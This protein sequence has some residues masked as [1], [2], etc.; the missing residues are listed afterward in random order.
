[1][2]KPLRVV[3]LGGGMIG[4]IHR[5]SAL[6]SGA[7]IVGTMASSPE[8]SNLLAASWDTHALRTL[9]EL[10]SFF[11]D[12]VHI[13]TPNSLHWEQT[14]A[15]L[16]CGA[17]V[18][19]EKPLATSYTQ[20]QELVLLAKN[21]GRIATV[22][23]IYRFH[24]LI[25]EIRARAI[26]GEFGK[27]QLLHGSYLQDWLL[28][29]AL[30]N[31]RVD[32]STGGESRTFAD[33]GSH[34]CDLIE[35][36]SGERIASLVANMATTVPMRPSD[37]TIMPDSSRVHCQTEDVC[38]VMFKTQSGVIGSVVVSQVSAGRKNRLWF[39]LDGERKSA[40]FDQ[41]KPETVWLGQ[42]NSASIL[43]RD[44]NVGSIDQKRLSVLPAGHPQGYAHCFDRFVE[45][46]YAS[47]VGGVCDGLPTFEDGAR[48]A[49]IVDAVL[50]STKSGTWVTV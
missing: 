46:T 1:M 11:P 26:E 22:P 27:W 18:I 50:K 19:C 13:C 47:I 41:E 12:V 36:V 20:A 23:F 29:P 33:I 9:D 30:T 39:E 3:I 8:R 45:D 40:V 7:S 32:S 2:S 35:F 44:P 48:S 31:W 14:K 43:F 25:R 15:A 38:T 17:H 49:R 21:Y 4:E 10:A 37:S 42:T 16:D 24:P 28:S 34:W 5:R 6:A